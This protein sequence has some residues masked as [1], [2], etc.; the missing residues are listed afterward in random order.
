MARRFLGGGA[1]SF[2][3]GIFSPVIYLSAIVYRTGG[4]AEEFILPAV[5]ISLYLLT[6]YFQSYGGRYDKQAISL[7]FRLGLL[8]GYIFFIKFSFVLLSAGLMLPLLIDMRIKKRP[9]LFFKALLA[10]IAGAAVIAAPYAIYA[11]A[12]DSVHAI[13]E[14]Y[15]KYNFL[16]SGSGGQGFLVSAL[17]GLTNLLNFAKTSIVEFLLMAAGLAYVLFINKKLPPVYRISLFCGFVFTVYSFARANLYI[18]MP[19][20]IYCV[21]GVIALAKAARFCMRG[22]AVFMNHRAALLSIFII[23]AFLFT[24]AENNVAATSSYNRMRMES[25]AAPPQ[26]TVADTVSADSPENRTLIEL[27]MLDGGFYTAAGIIPNT[28]FFYMP[29]E[30]DVFPQILQGQREAITNGSNTYAVF[31]GDDAQYMKDEANP[32]PFMQSVGILTDLYAET[33]SYPGYDMYEGRFAHLYRLKQKHMQSA[34]INGRWT[35]T[36]A[37]SPPLRQKG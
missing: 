24:I 29:N 19:L 3:V 28:R 23:S 33:G 11:F 1:A 26:E 34:A 35:P 4:S 21:F 30:S 31:W 7:F 17:N 20:T 16:Y 15:F 6:R 14:S 12:T 25:T 18:Y 2:A 5:A 13:I 32:D 22:N 27:H 8:A 9:A 36:T 10:A 37:C